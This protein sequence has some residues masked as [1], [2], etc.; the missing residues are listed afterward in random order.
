MLF[1]NNGSSLTKSLV[2][3]ALVNAAAAAVDSLKINS[4]GEKTRRG[5][6]VIVKRRNVHGEQ[7]ADLANLYFYLAGI[8]I[9]F[10][11]KVE[12]WRRWEVCCY[13]MLNGDRFD[14]AASGKRTIIEDKLPGK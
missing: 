12:D 2:P 13:K 1:G 6:R 8:P 9:R 3:E 4:L 10:W 7:M 5:R 14:V 11:S